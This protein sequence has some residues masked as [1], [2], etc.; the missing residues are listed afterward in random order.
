MVTG[1]IVNDKVNIASEYYRRARAMCDALFQTGHYYKSMHP[2]EK[3]GDEPKPELINNLNPLEGILSFIY[4]ITQTEERRL[5][6]DQR[7]KP[8]AIR[9]LYRRFLFYKHCVALQKPLVITE[10]KTDAVYL[11]AAI[12]RRTQFHPKLGQLNQDSFEFAVRF[13]SY[14]REIGRR[15][16]QPQP[17]SEIMDLGGGTGDLRSILMDYLY[18][19]DGKKDRK[20]FKHKP[21]Q[22]PVIL[23]LDNDSGLKDVAALIK[24][25]FGIAIS[26]KTT[27]PFYRIRDNIY[28]VKTPEGASESCIED[29]FPK[30]WL[31]RKL[32]GKTFN[33]NSKIDIA[34]EYSK[35]V[36]AKSV[37]LPN[38]GQIDFEGFDPLLD[39]I[40]KVLDD[41]VA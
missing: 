33:P 9:E 18:N 35:E 38:A 13:F 20:P 5:V 25:N 17:A 34:T 21:M 22:H 29:L 4:S 3:E 41:Y 10:G 11:R 24:T 40:A 14:G 37:V 2:P 15:G 8:R 23:V 26:T 16:K 19:I 28:L 36:F 7:Q 30:K 6:Q 32:N 39:R 27:D 31:K 1:L 12:K